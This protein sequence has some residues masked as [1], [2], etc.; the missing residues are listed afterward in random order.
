MS[1]TAKCNATKDFLRHIANKVFAEALEKLPSSVVTEFRKRLGRLEDKY[2]FS[3]Y[4]G[5]P[6]RLAEA[7]SS[8]EWREL[9]E[10]AEKSNVVWLIRKILEKAAEAYKDTCPTV[11]EKIQA[12]RSRL[13]RMEEKEG[14]EELTSDELYRALKYKGYR[15]EVGQD[16]DIFV[17]E[18]NVSARLKV[19]NGMIEYEI[20]RTGKSSS[21]DS[22][23]IKIDKIKEL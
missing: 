7:L 19:A 11:Y 15:V 1:V 18:T 6:E 17:S 4:G 3:I 8:P 22:I 13:A 5:R 21:I 9:V 20:C 14:V 10:Y 2:D 12:E 23:L 16:G